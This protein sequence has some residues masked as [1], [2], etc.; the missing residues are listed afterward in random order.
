MY[1]SID[2][3]GVGKVIEKYILLERI[4]ELSKISGKIRGYTDTIVEKIIENEGEI[5]MQG[6]DNILAQIT[7]QAIDKIMETIDEINKEQI[8]QFSVGISKSVLG[9]YMALKYAKS[10]ECNRK[11]EFKDAQFYKI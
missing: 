9:A 3:D 6:G 8:I 7:D 2:G 5:I 4:P 11:I 1:I 10:L